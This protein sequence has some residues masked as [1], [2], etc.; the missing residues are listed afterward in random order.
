MRAQPSEQLREAPVIIQGPADGSSSCPTSDVLEATTSSI[1][2]SIRARFLLSPD[3][4]RF[5]W[6]QVADL[7]MEVASQQ[8]PS[9]WIEVSCASSISTAGCEGVSFPVSGGTY[10]RVCG[11]VVGYAIRTP[12][13]FYLSYRQHLYS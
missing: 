10:T 7:D 8:C 11:K 1:F 4:G 9:S 5:G 6:R 12:A 3:C 2:E 13:A